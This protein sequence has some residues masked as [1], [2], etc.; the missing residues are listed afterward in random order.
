MRIE[1]S[2]RDYLEFNMVDSRQIDVHSCL[3]E[4]ELCAHPFH[5][6]SSSEFDRWDICN[7]LTELS[8]LKDSLKGEATLGI[9]GFSSNLFAVKAIN[10]TGQFSLSATLRSSDHS[11][12]QTTLSHD[13][14]FYTSQLDEICD[15]FSQYFAK[16]RVVA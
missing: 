11:P 6:I 15:A 10:S 12:V 1:F 9:D 14:F 3:L 16:Y 13:Y 2:E 8:Q 4:T 5:G 7:F